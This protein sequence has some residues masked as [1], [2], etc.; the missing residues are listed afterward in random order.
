MKNKTF[1]YI[2]EGDMF[3]IY[4]KSDEDIVGSLPVGNFVFDVGISGKIV[5]LEIDNASEIFGI[6]A[7]KNIQ[8]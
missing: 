4:N 7:K 2:A 5:G 1:E 3:Y 8:R 6:S